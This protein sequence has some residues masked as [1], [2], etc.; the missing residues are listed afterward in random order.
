[1]PSTAPSRRWPETSASP[2]PGSNPQIDYA[3]IEQRLDPLHVLAGLGYAAA[4]E[5]RRTKG[6]W[7]TLLWRFQ[8]PDGRQH[9][10]RI[11]VLPG[12][13][14]MA[15]RERL[16]LKACAG[17]GLPAPRVEAVGQFED[18]PV[19]VLSWCPGF[20]ILSYVEKKPWAL[21]RFARL[22]GRAQ[23]QMHAVKPPPEFVPTAPGDWIS[24]VPDRYRDLADHA[25]SLGLST[26]S[27][28]HMDFHP[29]N[30]VSDGAAVTGIVDWPR[31][32]AGDP[33][34]D[35]AR[36]V[37]T[38]LTAPLPPGPLS[39]ILN[40]LRKV[41][42]RG[43][44]SGYEEVAG[45]MPNYRSLMAWAGATLLDEVEHVIDRP[46]VWG[47]REDMEKL[48]RMVSIWARQGG[49]R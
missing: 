39:Q 21:W 6:G 2:S 20:P 1:M 44:R 15:W 33:R 49:I 30:V 45:P 31:S 43:W 23:A 16:A 24:R 42:L 36:T 22:F 12:R 25:S 11:H 47:T 48:E 9:S 10:L 40:L 41:M 14:Q 4:A 29:L 46:E 8:T 35:L 34:A 37:I 26:D 28:I 38:M 32:A 13:E 19:M 18:M 5:L 17:A 27:L 7:D 3:E